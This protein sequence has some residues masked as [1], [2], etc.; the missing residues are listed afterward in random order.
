MSTLQEI[1]LDKKENNSY[2]CNIVRRTARVGL[3]IFA[4]KCILLCPES[5]A[6]E[7]ATTE[8]HKVLKR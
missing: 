2:L 8:N 3:C 6:Y 5:L 7:Q 1:V 4:K